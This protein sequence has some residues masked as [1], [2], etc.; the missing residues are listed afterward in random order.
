M[1]AHAHRDL[2]E[3]NRL[4]WNEATKVHN[5]HKGDQTA[6]LRDG[7]TTLFPEEIDLLGDLRGRRLLH[8]QCNSGQD[9]L[10][11]AGRGAE[12]TGVDI[13][14]EAV[15]FASRLSADSGIPGRFV[16]AD[17]YDWLAETAASDERWDVVFSSYGAIIWLSDL[18]AWA[19]GI[20]A[21]LRPGGRFCLVEFHP[22]PWMFNERWDFEY[23]YTS[24][25]KPMTFDGGIGDY[26][27][28]SGAGLVAG[29]GAPPGGAA[30]KNPHRS[31]EFAWGLSDLFTALIGAGLA[32]DVFREYPYSNGFKGFDGM[33]ELAGRRWAPP[34][35]IPWMPMMYA[36]AARKPV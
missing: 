29:D 2:H 28:A 23:P 16:R 3:D 21:V 25:G 12:V 10:S 17:V 30:F 5:S 31:H 26:V 19:K 24:E 34:S 22:V 32:I 33:V 8:L 1:T 7:G 6:F 18:A 13:S 15:A 20:A 27:G 11:L 4:S 9:T 35:R 36:I 14:D